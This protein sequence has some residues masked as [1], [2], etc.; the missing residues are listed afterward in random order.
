MKKNEFNDDQISY[1]ELVNLYLE[2]D[3]STK[4]RKKQIVDYVVKKHLYLVLVEVSKY[5]RSL[6]F[7]DMIQEGNIGLMRAAEKFDH[8][9]GFKFATYA[10]WW[11]KQAILRFTDLH[12][13]QIRLP[14][15]VH[16]MVMKVKSI[17]NSDISSCGD[18]AAELGV[19]DEIAHAILSAAK[20]TVSLDRCI[21]TSAGDV[22][23][24]NKVSSSDRQQDL[25]LEDC[26]LLES[27]RKAIKKLSP[28]EEAVLLL[29]LGIDG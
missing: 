11:I 24:M 20:G 13:R 6:Y 18:I 25:L 26:D 4:E 5:R 15:H 16:S 28:R 7:D 27:L 22:S 14:S 10:R 2:I 12:S 17:A 8:K 3:V 23:L 9:K 19:S 21:K 1:D 29:R